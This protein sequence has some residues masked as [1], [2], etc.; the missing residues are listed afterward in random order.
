MANK[1]KYTPAQI[2]KAL[3]HAGGFVTQAA[4]HL[5]CTYQTIYNYLNDPDT[6]EALKDVLFEIEEE[7]KDVAEYIVKTTLREE[8]SALIAAIAKNSKLPAKDRKRVI[9]SP[10]GVANAFRFLAYKA[11]DRGYV[12]RSELTGAEGAELGLGV[13][14]LPPLDDEVGMD[15]PAAPIT[16]KKPKKK[17]PTKKKAVKKKPAKKK[18]AKK[19]AK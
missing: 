14:G 7:G 19:K 2:E 17:K 11:K 15:A 8:A 12:E 18:P 3:R 10:S 6:G 16:P 1:K 9:A 5:G 4:R 13:V